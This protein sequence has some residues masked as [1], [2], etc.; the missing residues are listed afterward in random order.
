MDFESMWNRS[1]ILGEPADK[2]LGPA[3]PQVFNAFLGVHRLARFR[4]ESFEAFRA[5]SFF[6]DGYSAV[7]EHSLVRACPTNKKQASVQLVLCCEYSCKA[8]KRL[9]VRCQALQA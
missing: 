8:M 4:S 9:A 3:R 1:S 5:F 6:R 7:S 2:V